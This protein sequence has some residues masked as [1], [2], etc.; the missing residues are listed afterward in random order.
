M[1]KNK[2]QQTTTPPVVEDK[3]EVNPE[4][5][6]ARVE[7]A[8]AMGFEVE[9]DQTTGLPIAAA[10]GEAIWSGEGDFQEWVKSVMDAGSDEKL[11]V[12]S[13]G[14]QGEVT[15]GNRSEPQL[16]LDVKHVPKDPAEL[17]KEDGVQL[18]AFA[19]RMAWI[20]SHGT[21]HE[22]YVKNVLT[23]YVQVGLTSV[24]LEKIAVEQKRLWRLFAY[25][26]AHP[27]E[28][29]KLYNI[30]I[31]FAREYHDDLF[32]LHMFFRAQEGLAMGA[33]EMQCFN[34]LRTLVLNTVEAKSKQAVKSILDIR[35]IVDHNLIPEHVRGMYVAF[36]Q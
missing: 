8:R 13:Q 9:V 6:Q 18:S 27:Q 7:N 15:E 34:N 22:Q 14:P 31:E 21:T 3:H 33:D 35:K 23:N 11:E 10:K 32:N 36:Y 28:F 26:H 4:L 12:T 2:Q 20:E 19:T 24:D 25:L 16:G 5:I 29:S 30:V 17:I 1:S